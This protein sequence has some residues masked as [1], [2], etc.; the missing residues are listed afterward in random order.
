MVGDTVWVDQACGDTDQYPYFQAK[1]IQIILDGSLTNSIVIR[2]RT[3]VHDLMI[4]NGIYDMKPLGDR[5]G[6]KRIAVIVD[7]LG[8]RRSLF[9][10][11]KEL[12][13]YQNR[14]N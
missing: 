11:E 10:T 4:S 3:E 2:E 13:D 9:L 12:I 5:A 1:I 14:A 8:P 7:F 6:L